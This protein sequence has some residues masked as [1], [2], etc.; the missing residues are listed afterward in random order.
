LSSGASK[1]P[2][3]PSQKDFSLTNFCVGMKLDSDHCVHK[4]AYF[5]FLVTASKFVS[6]TP[7]K[8]QEGSLSF[9]SQQQQFKRSL[10]SGGQQTG[11]V[12]QS[13]QNFLLAR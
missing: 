12:H 13:R 10:Y 4:K 6:S 11:S 3:F 8:N 9:G 1:N 5:I 7:K 2:I